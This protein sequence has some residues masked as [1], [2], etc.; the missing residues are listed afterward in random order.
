MRKT[1]ML[2]VLALLAIGA[3]AAYAD[4]LTG[5]I[6]LGLGGGI[7]GLTGGRDSVQ[8][9]VPEA[10]NAKMGLQ[11]MPVS[12]K[13]GIWRYTTLEFA[14][15][16]YGFNKSKLEGEDNFR[17][18]VRPLTANLLFPISP[19]SQLTP[20]LVAGGGVLFWTNTQKDSLDQR[21]TATGVVGSSLGRKLENTDPLWNLGL[22][23]EYFLGGD[24][25]AERH[26][27]LDARFTYGTFHNELTNVGLHDNN[28][29]LWMLTLGMNWY[30]KK[31]APP[32][33]PPPPP[34][35]EPTPAPA[36]PPPP[37]APEPVKEEPA[38]AGPC[39]KEG[40]L[41]GVYFDFDKS[42]VK[43]EFNPT[44]N[45]LADKLVKECPNAE[46]ELDGHTD[47]KGSAAYN[48]KLGQRRADAVKK[49]LT[50]HGVD[51]SRLST[52]SFGESKPVAPNMVDGK[53]SPENRAKN[54]RVE[55]AV[56]KQ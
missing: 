30:S 2:A 40:A 23:L 28:N 13:W 49:Y 21:T 35:P 5:R 53:D 54:R 16:H 33:P 1:W 29:K 4:D 43:P 9:G 24:T 51:A 7:Y 46:L 56:T 36:P 18:T 27:S 11:V 25:E 19:G 55:L 41:E 6:G 15:F 52:K 14:R 34:A 8:N 39:I 12:L 22:G 31:A 32:P 48:M 42:V 26:K 3:T 47:G 20:Y 17:T 44:L 38:P 45:D 37:P 50:E 10:S